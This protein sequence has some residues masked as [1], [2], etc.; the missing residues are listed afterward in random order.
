MFIDKGLYKFIEEDCKID[1]SKPLIGDDLDEW[2]N[3][4]CKPSTF[5][6]EDLEKMGM[7]VE[8]DSNRIPY[9]RTPYGNCYIKDLPG[10]KEK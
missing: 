1:W 8:Y 2:L 4:L 5:T 3:Q 9:L 10:Y 6:K 7:H